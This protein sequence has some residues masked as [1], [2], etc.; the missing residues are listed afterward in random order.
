MYSYDNDS[1]ELIPVPPLPGEGRMGFGLAA[2]DDNKII[3]VG[4]HNFNFECMATVS[5]LDTRAETWQWQNL[6]DMPSKL[7]LFR[8]QKA[9]AWFFSEMAPLVRVSVLLRMS[10]TSSVDSTFLA[11]IPSAMGKKKR[12]Y[13]RVLDKSPSLAMYWY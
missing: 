13:K 9:C 3:S 10:Y 1:K 8:R 11:R 6:P 12:A 5:M 7:T 4:G 2:T